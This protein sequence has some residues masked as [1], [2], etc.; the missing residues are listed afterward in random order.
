MAQTGL[1]WA[2]GVCDSGQHVDR[3]CLVPLPGDRQE[4]TSLSGLCC[5]GVLCSQLL[6]T[7]MQEEG[8]TL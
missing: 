7:S 6:G 2:L 1:W 8:L 3:E 5:L 4:G